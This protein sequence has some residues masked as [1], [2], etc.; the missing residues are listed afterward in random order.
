MPAAEL[1]AEPE[2]EP[3]RTGS[4]AGPGSDG[5]SDAGSGSDFDD[6]DLDLG[7]SDEDGELDDGEDVPEFV[8]NGT[9]MTKEEMLAARDRSGF[10]PA[11]EGLNPE[12][13]KAPHMRM[14]KF[15]GRPPTCVFGLGCG[16]ASPA[17]RRSAL[18]F[19]ELF[20]PL[21]WITVRAG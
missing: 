5:G 21:D 8:V 6:D 2:P 14:S 7:S 11:A 10:V 15:A 1:A 20:A 12:M 3:Q 13:W 4:A 17:P 9:P 16:P 18:R 19:A